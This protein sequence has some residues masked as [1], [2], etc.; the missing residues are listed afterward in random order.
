MRWNLTHQLKKQW[1]AFL[2]EQRRTAPIQIHITG[3]NCQH[4]HMQFPRLA[5]I[6][7]PKP[8]SQKITRDK[9]AEIRIWAKMHGKSFSNVILFYYTG[10]SILSPFIVRLQKSVHVHNKSLVLA[11]SEINTVISNLYT[12]CPICGPWEGLGVGNYLFLCAR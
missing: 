6:K 8:T 11:L 4:L 12:H 7:I 1:K 9:E 5:C 10:S 2:S 3:T